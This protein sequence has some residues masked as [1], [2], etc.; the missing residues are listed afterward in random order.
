MATVSTYL[1]FKRETEQAF[2]FYKSVFGTEFSGMGIARFGALLREAKL[3]VYAL[4][5]VDAS[6][7]RPLKAAGAAGLAVI[8]AVFGSRD[9]ASAVAG[10]LAAWH[11]T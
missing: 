11:D 2:N 7:A 6:Y 10:L 1:N 3:P 4:G 9:P 5:G 8:S